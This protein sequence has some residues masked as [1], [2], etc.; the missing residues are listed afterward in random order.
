MNKKL[1]QLIDES[2]QLELK[3]ADI[4][5][6]FYNTF[7][8]DSEFWRKL[9]LEE[10]DHADL[11]KSGKSTFLIPN[12]FPSKLLVPSV[13]TLC[14]ISDKLTSLHKQYNE[15]PPSRE[16]AFNTALDIE[17]SAGEFHF[18]LA[19]EQSP[20]SR[21]IELLQVMNDGCKDHAKRILADLSEKGIEV[22]GDK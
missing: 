10:K 18:Q 17:K 19:M 2:I 7:P 5:T 16:S 6:I 3:V 13:Q 11:I 20:N 8:E 14:E 15:K 21:I 22:R 9:V 4:Y 12:Q 1:S